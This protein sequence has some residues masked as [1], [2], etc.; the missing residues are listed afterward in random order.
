MRTNLLVISFY[1]PPFKRVG[2]RRWAKHVKY[3]NRSGENVFVL[4]GEF[5]NSTSPWDDDILEYNDKITRLTLKPAYKPYFETT[6]PKNLSDKIRW[7]LSYH[8]W[9]VRKKFLT[10][11]FAD[12]SLPNKQI[13]FE[14]A[15]SIITKNNISTVILSVGPFAYSR[16]LID[17]KKE[18]KNIKCIIDYRD[19]WEESIS[20]LTAA[21]QK[22]EL[23]DQLNVLKA[24][25]LVLTVNEDISNNIRNIN[26]KVKVITLPHCVDE[27]FLK[28][29][30]AIKSE[31]KNESLKFIYGG[32]LYGGLEQEMRN[33]VDF[34]DLFSKE[35]KQN[36][37]ADFYSPYFSYET[38]LNNKVGLNPMLLKEE[39]QTTLSNSD[40]ILLFKSPLSTEAFFSSKFYE[41]LCLRK[42]LLFFGKKG[43][44]SDF[45]EKHKL[46]F[47]IQ[48]NNLQEM[49]SAIIE[50]MTTKK[51]PAVG[52]DLQ[53]H[54][55]EFHTKKLVVEI[56][57]LERVI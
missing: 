20:D 47:H 25:D 9:N 51:I 56:K 26:K 27:D 50:N 54:S 12:A 49:I 52:Y 34:F 36:C 55:F 8:I 13:F 4:T 42:P 37:K 29:S 14:T 39:Y 57:N 2:G 38:I 22:K 15:K 40:F 41:M 11:N 44:V 21:Q 45:I 23:D 10:G 18:F 1:F 33:F 28:I 16:V 17:L 6:L 19:P 5:S 32:E 43:L 7:K 3:L 35:V 48:K 31:T 53:Q 46:G 24:V 30:T